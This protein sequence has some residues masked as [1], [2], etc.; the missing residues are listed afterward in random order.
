[1]G[2][3]QESVRFLTAA[4]LPVRWTCAQCRRF[5]CWEPSPHIGSTS[6][7]G[8]QPEPP[9]GSPWVPRLHSSPERT[10]EL[11]ALLNI[12]LNVF[13]A[14]NSGAVLPWGG[15]GRK[16]KCDL[17]LPPGVL[18]FSGRLVRTFHMCCVLN[19]GPVCAMILFSCHFV[20]Q[21]F[22]FLCGT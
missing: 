19:P 17:P 1:M 12:V 21:L 10:P 16:K 6:V 5:A 11:G 18:G 4:I 14:I 2:E 15:V 20:F 9:P 8:T 13:L 7:K 22:V 3:R